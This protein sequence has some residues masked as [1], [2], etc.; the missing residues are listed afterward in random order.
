M[1]K[2]KRVT[3]FK[4]PLFKPAQV[5]DTRFGIRRIYLNQNEKPQTFSYADPAP[6]WWGTR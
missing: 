4:K 3:E 6:G 1:A 2:D 5:N